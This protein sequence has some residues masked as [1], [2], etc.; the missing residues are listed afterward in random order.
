MKNRFGIVAIGN[1]LLSGKTLD[2]NTSWIAR[3]LANVGWS[4]CEARIVG[5]KKTQIIQ[6]LAGVLE[7]CELC[8]TTGG[9]GPTSDDITR[10]AVASFLD[11]DLEFSLPVLEKLEAQ[12][13]RKGRLLY[14]SGKRQAYFPKGSE[15]LANLKG[16]ADAFRVETADSRQIFSLPGV[17]REMK[18]LVEQF[19]VP[20]ARRSLGST[21]LSERYLRCFGLSESYI[22]QTLDALELPTE[23]QVAYRPQFPVVMVTLGA[24]NVELLDAVQKQCIEAL[25]AQYVFSDREE[26]TLSQVVGSLVREQGKTLS[27]AE[28]CT[29]GELAS[30]AVS[31]PG[32][33]EYFL[34]SIVSYSNKVKERLLGVKPQTLETSGAVSAEVAK[35]MAQG[36]DADIAVS[37]TGIAGPGGGTAEKPV[38]TIWIGLKLGNQLQAFQYRL[39]LERNAFRRYSA[40]LGLDMVRRALL[41]LNLQVERK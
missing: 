33:S 36:V 35:E 18:Y 15:I 16:T 19:V 14:E 10:D 23:V 31:A 25:G 41:G 40:Y 1:E 34:G 2:S 13:E 20:W 21:D 4:L 8:I 39:P 38:G 3:E 22:G 11:V 24:S 12:A 30:L 27:F 29:G 28:S 6:A 7:Q 17:P 9:L 26:D 32:S 37:T 5:D